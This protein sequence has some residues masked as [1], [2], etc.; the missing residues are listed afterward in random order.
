[1]STL[2]MERISNQAPSSALSRKITVD[3]ARSLA[4]R[5]LANSGYTAEYRRIICDQIVDSE[6]RDCPS[7]GLMRCVTLCEYR[8][9]VDGAGPMTVRKVNDVVTSIDA[10]GVIGYVAAHAA[11]NAA[12]R[13]AGQGGVGVACAYNTAYTGMYAY[14][15]QMVTAKGLASFMAGNSAPFVTPHGGDRPILGTN[16][17]AFGF[18][19]DS[20]PVIFDAGMSETVRAKLV[21]QRCISTDA[22]A[23]RTGSS[24]ATPGDK[25]SIEA[26]PSS[27]LR[28]WGGYRGSALAVCVQFMGILAGGSI[29]P[30]ELAGGESGFICITLDPAVILGRGLD[31]RALVSEFSALVRPQT[32]GPDGG[33]SVRL[34]FERS[35]RAKRITADR[36]YFYCS[37]KI[38]ERLRAMAPVSG[39]GH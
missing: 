31:Y 9:A 25:H 39:R 18:P 27:T 38:F 5:A 4:L 23:S 24:P 16:P 21:F 28:P 6:L 15:M 17:I 35:A 20:D 11:T 26:G 36:G 3:D 2:A 12:I 22:Q 14:Y 34:P 33:G 30:N 8:R 19:S 37:D 1:M 10:K 7:S 29:Q 32:D 13:S